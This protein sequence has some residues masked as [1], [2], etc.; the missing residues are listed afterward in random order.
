MAPG[1][2][3]SLCSCQAPPKI[4]L[5][6]LPRILKP[7]PISLRK[8]NSHSQVLKCF[9]NHKCCMR[10]AI[11][12]WIIDGYFIELSALIHPPFEVLRR[13]KE[14][15]FHNMLIFRGKVHFYNHFFFFFFFPPPLWNVIVAEKEGWGTF[16]HPLKCL[17]SSFGCS[18][19]F[20][21]PLAEV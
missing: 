16:Q 17:Y 20:L 15:S 14:S 9:P 2:E 18:F 1:E 6:F 5:F 11:T 4:P 8:N 21:P 19:L 7:G 12:F 10:R 3:T 13:S